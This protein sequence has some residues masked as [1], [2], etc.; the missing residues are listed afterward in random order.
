MPIC[1]KIY[2]KQYF[3]FLPHKA[4]L[5]QNSCNQNKKIK[6]KVACSSCVFFSW[7]ECTKLHIQE[8]LNVADSMTETKKIP[9]TGDTES[10]NRCK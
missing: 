4:L 8:L 3:P 1:L 6:I 10:P 9:H 5:E 2:L 7:K